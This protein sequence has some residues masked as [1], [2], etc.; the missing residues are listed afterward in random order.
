[1]LICRNADGVHGQRK[2]GNPWARALSSADRF[3]WL[4]QLK[5]R[6]VGRVSDA[7]HVT[8][9]RRQRILPPCSGRREARSSEML[10][11]DEATRRRRPGDDRDG[12]RLRFAARQRRRNALRR[13]GYR[14]LGEAAHRS[15]DHE[16]AVVL[17]VRIQN[18]F[19]SKVVAG[20]CCAENESPS[21]G[22]SPQNSCSAQCC[23]F[24]KRS[25]APIQ[26]T[27]PNLFLLGLVH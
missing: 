24:P 22:S 6:N 20:V 7:D 10:P 11:C 2:V 8:Y 21:S 26:Y 18:C 15:D 27:A 13:Q 3:V 9:I 1:M 14:A 16:L 25:C 12:A 4:G 23:T 5:P 17:Q 19:V